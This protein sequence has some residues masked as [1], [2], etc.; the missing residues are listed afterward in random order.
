MRQTFGPGL[1]IRMGLLAFSLLMLAGCGGGSARISNIEE[2]GTIGLTRVVGLNTRGLVVTEPT[3]IHAS[4][5]DA[6]SLGDL[7]WDAFSGANPD[8]TS[9]A[10]SNW[11]GLWTDAQIRYDFRDRGDL[12]RIRLLGANTIRVYSMLS[13]QLDADNLAFPSPPAGRRFSHKQF[14]DMCWNNGNTR[15]MWWST[16]PCPLPA[17]RNGSPRTSPARS[18]GGRP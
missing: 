7:F 11:Y 1:R 14:L 18:R 9:S 8:G 2:I 13:R 12:D 5:Q 16:S 17:S 4:S 3:P 15:C 6:P 10:I